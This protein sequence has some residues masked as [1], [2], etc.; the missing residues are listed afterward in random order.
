M[1]GV[2]AGCKATGTKMIVMEAKPEVQIT[3]NTACRNSAVS[4]LQN[5][6]ALKAAL[7]DHS[8]TAIKRLKLRSTGK[9]EKSTFRIMKIE[10]T[11]NETCQGKA[12]NNLPPLR[13]HE[14][15]ILQHTKTMALYSFETD[16]LINNRQLSPGQLSVP[17][18][19]FESYLLPVTQ[20]TWQKA[21]DFFREKK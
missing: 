11:L 3:V 19:G 16:T 15:L 1:L 6:D 21:K 18:A 12:D 4:P 5:E 20:V 13:L 14:K 10:L 2:L 7:Q 8:T 9:E 17:K